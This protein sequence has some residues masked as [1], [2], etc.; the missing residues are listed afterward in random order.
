MGLSMELPS[1][2][3]EELLPLV[4]DWHLCL[5]WPGNVEAREGLSVLKDTTQRALE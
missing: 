3:V 5:G 2:R 4:V 1:G